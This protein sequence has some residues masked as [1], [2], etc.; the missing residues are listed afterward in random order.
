[1]NFLMGMWREGFGDQEVFPEEGFKDRQ[2]LDRWRELQQHRQRVGMSNVGV[3]G[4]KSNMMYLEHS[5]GK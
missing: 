5:I 1:M 2:G 3:I 4:T